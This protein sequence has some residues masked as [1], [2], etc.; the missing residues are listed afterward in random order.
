MSGLPFKSVSLYPFPLSRISFRISSI[1]GSSTSLQGMKKNKIKDA[2]SP[3]GC[4]D[5]GLEFGDGR[6]KGG[7]TNKNNNVFGGTGE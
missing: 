1:G 6:I 5:R 7:E 3:H 2:I 4:R